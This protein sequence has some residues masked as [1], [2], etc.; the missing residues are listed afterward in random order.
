MRGGAPR[1]GAGRVRRGSAMLKRISARAG[2]AP[3]QA[4]VGLRE[5]GG[6]AGSRFRI[7]KG[8]RGVGGGPRK[9]RSCRMRLMLEMGS[10]G[11]P[12]AQG[13]DGFRRRGPRN[14]RGGD[15]SWGGRAGGGAGHVMWRGARG[16]LLRMSLGRGFSGPVLK[17]CG[18][19]K[20]GRIRPPQ[21]SFG[22]LSFGWGLHVCGANFLM[23][24]KL[25]FAV[26]LNMGSLV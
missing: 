1:G 7:G 23:G 3:V 4:A 22:S 11:R 2:L 24:R 25:K 18:K 14:R 6:P 19:G 5:G 12:G 17:K 21:G 10:F 9:T 20:M 8:G 16:W 15:G 13:L 26:F